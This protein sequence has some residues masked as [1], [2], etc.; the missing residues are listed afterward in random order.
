MVNIPLPNFDES[1]PLIEE[2]RAHINS[3]KSQ[4]LTF[5][6]CSNGPVILLP[7]FKKDN[8][9]PRITSS[10]MADILQGVYSTKYTNLYIVDCRYRYEY[11]GGHLP[12]ALH[13]DNPWNM[14][15]YFF[16]NPQ[17]ILLLFFIVNSLSNVVLKW[18]SFSVNTIGQSM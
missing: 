9:I 13:F 3:S 17:K 6:K 12:D 15:K 18:L 2:E 16:Q 8:C 14:I 7:S 1:S 4:P 5:K 10:T 11:D